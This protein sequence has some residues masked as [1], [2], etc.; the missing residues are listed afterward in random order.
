MAKAAIAFDVPDLAA[1]A[2]S[3]SQF[4]LDQLQFG[5]ILLDDHDNVRF[6]SETEARQSGYGQLPLGQ[7]LFALSSCL[8]SD[9]FRG[10]IERARANGTVDI[11]FD[12]AGDYNDPKRTMHIRVQTARNG[13][14]WLFIDRPGGAQAHDPA[15]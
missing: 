3:A 7:N 2:E 8:G 14:L 1:R 5:V 13:G 15:A 9:A 11:T 4:E 12:W 10:R 6:Y